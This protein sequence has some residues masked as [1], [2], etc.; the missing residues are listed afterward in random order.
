MLSFFASFASFTSTLSK[1]IYHEDLLMVK[2]ADQG[3]IS[4]NRT[5]NIG[6]I[7]VNEYSLLSIIMLNLGIK[8]E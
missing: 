8:H 5:F 2:Q 7:E 1:S 4:S 3:E 6:L